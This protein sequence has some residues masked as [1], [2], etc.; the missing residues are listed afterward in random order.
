MYVT[1]CLSE[2][3]SQDCVDEIAVLVFDSFPVVT[4]QRCDA[5]VVACA[6]DCFPLSHVHDYSPGGIVSDCDDTEDGIH[7]A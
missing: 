5:E 1:H 7:V 4:E 3:V 6:S 2:M